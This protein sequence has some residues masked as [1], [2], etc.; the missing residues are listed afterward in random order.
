MRAELCTLNMNMYRECDDSR[1]SQCE[2]VDSRCM[3]ERRV[4]RVHSAV[5]GHEMMGA[6]YAVLASVAITA[7]CTQ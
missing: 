1:T 5:D 3:L 7:H 2:V 4:Q 6:V